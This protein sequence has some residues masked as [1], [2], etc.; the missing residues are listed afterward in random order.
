MFERYVAQVRLLLDVMPDIAAEPAFALKGGTAI[1]LFYRDMPRLS[2]DI[3][4]VWLPVS[5]RLSALRDIDSTFERIATAIAERNPRLAVRRIAGGGNSDTRIV[6]IYNSVQIKIETSPVAR[7][8]VFSA[9]PMVASEAVATQFGFVE[10]NVLTFEDLYGG[11][12]VA[13]LDRRH[14]RDLF[15]VKLLYDNEGLTDDLFQVFMVYLAGSRR[16]MHELLAPATPL[17]HD[18][19]DDEFAGMTRV[20]TSQEALVEAGR[21]LH[22]DIGMRLTDKVASFLLSLHDAEPDFELIGLPEA[23]ELPAI[24]WK[25]VNLERLK[26]VDP[27]KHARQRGA[28]ERLLR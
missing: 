2:V 17:R 21:R 11:K 20:A 23:A 25:V 14:P 8:A 15:D 3:D 16:P 26:R 7:G 27:K 22:A 5:D 6:V 13:A 18:W 1:N 4:L 28:L 19:Y 10:T 24:R 12:L 9:R